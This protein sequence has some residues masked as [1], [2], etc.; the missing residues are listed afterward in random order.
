MAFIFNFSTDRYLTITKPLTYGTLRTTKRMLLFIATV[1]ITS[2]LISIPPV[3]M[4]GN[5]HGTQ[6][7]PICQVSQN[8]G[9]QL[10]ATLGA[11]YIPLVVMIVMYYKIYVAAKRVVEAELRDQR[12]SCSSAQTYSFT[13]GKHNQLEPP[14]RIHYNRFKSYHI[15]ADKSVTNST[16]AAHLNRHLPNELANVDK[17]SPCDSAEMSSRNKLNSVHSSAESMSRSEQRKP[18]KKSR[19]SNREKARCEQ[20]DSNASLCSC[21]IKVEEEE[22]KMCSELKTDTHKVDKNDV[23]TFECVGNNVTPT[24]TETKRTNCTNGAQ[25]RAHINSVLSSVGRKS[26]KERSFTDSSQQSSS[27]DIKRRSSALRERKASFTLGK[28]L[29]YFVVVRALLH[30]MTTESVLHLSTPN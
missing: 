28:F 5:E 26:I 27:I 22:V 13:F 11:F 17:C 16:P 18:G 20:V 2:C 15:N 21:C 9:Y 25:Q 6:Y 24:M 10:Y 4:L 14:L 19:K 1:W 29:I 3:L 12:P 30:S 23:I 8:I 7:H